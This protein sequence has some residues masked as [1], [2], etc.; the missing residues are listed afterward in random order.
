[1]TPLKE[2]SLALSLEAMKLGAFDEILMPFD[3]ETLLDRIR[4]ASGK[5][6]KG[7]TKHT[8]Q[9]RDAPQRL[10]R[11]TAAERARPPKGEVCGM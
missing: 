2:H 1:M 11:E 5:K 9:R 6:K 8:L 7:Q 4:A 3:V 10:T